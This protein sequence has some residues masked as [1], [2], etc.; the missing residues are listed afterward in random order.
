[1]AVPARLI[2][3][4]GLGRRAD[5]GAQ[6]WLSIKYLS[7]PRKLGRASWAAQSWAA[8]SWAA[9]HIIGWLASRMLCEPAEQDVRW[10]PRRFG[11]GSTL[12]LITGFPRLISYE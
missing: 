3:E 8:Q 9:P 10:R 12:T 2:G 6:R 7:W 5:R 4:C 11:P 1:M